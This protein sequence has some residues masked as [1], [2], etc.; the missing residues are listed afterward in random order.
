MGAIQK[1]CSTKIEE[2][3]SLYFLRTIVPKLL[4]SPTT[5]AKEQGT[6]QRKPSDCL[7]DLN[8]I[9]EEEEDCEKLKEE[10]SAFQHFSGGYGDGN[11][12]T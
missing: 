11:W 7:D 6:K 3:N 4:L 1:L 9:V 10:L 8:K 2:V 5:S 12:T